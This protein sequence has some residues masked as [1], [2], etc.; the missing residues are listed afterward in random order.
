MVERTQQQ[1]IYLVTDGAHG[2]A[3]EVRG[4]LVVCRLS[5]G[6]GH[7]ADM[8]IHPLSVVRYLMVLLFRH[9]VV[10]GE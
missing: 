7:E 5:G 4:V 9:G 8:S 1:C 10:V 6:D 3:E 2:G